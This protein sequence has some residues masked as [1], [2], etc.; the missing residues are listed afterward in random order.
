VFSIEYVTSRDSDTPEERIEFDGTDLQCAVTMAEI[1][2]R[3][4]VTG[5]RRIAPVIGY[6]IRDESGTVVRRLYK[7]IP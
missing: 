4:I 6:L 7:W 2:L 3:D 5:V 1:V